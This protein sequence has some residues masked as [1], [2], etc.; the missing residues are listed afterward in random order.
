MISYQAAVARLLSLGPELKAGKFALEGITRLCAAL[1][2]PQLASPSVLD[3][4]ISYGCINVPAAFYDKVVAPA[5]AGRPSRRDRAPLACKPDRVRRD[6]RGG[7]DSCGRPWG[8]SPG[9]TP[10]C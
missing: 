4:R 9:L 10:R 1:G 2:D 3:N 5:F 7:G 6:R 8:A